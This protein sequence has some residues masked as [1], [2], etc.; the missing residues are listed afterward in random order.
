MAWDTFELTE[1][2]TN[3]IQT[4]DEIKDG[5]ISKLNRVGTV[6]KN[7]Q[8][9]IIFKVKEGLQAKLNIEITKKGDGY[10]LI[11]NGVTK[12]QTWII[13]CII[14]FF[15][16]SLYYLPFIGLGFLM[17]IVFYSYKGKPKQNIVEGIK[18]TKLQFE[19]TST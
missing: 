2:I 14:P 4:K 18:S 19:N 8:G 11:V 17:L 7:E 16:I 9:E 10:L 15:L 3:T 13:I 6:V 5:F 1:V 12:L